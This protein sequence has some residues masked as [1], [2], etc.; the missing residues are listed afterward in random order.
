MSVHEAEFLRNVR[1][2]WLSVTVA[3]VLSTAPFIPG[4]SAQPATLLTYA[5]PLS[6]A[7]VT[8][9][10]Q[11]LKQA[12]VTQA[13]QMECGVGTAQ[14]PWSGSSAATGC[15]SRGSSTRQRLRPLASTL[16]SCWQ[17][18]P[19]ASRQLLRRSL[20]QSRWRQRSCA[21]YRAVFG[22]S[23]STPA[24]SMDSGVPPCSPPSSASSRGGVCKQL[25]SSTL[26]R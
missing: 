15:R 5:Q 13:A 1:M 25:G 2:K 19:P 14:L 3:I 8:A 26:L 20:L 17:W 22:S 12:G 7:G 6:P 21:Q 18:P 4:A 11:R 24:R 23:A 16:G 9:V 10:Q